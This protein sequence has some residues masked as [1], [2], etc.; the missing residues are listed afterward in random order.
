M[1]NLSIN[2]LLCSKS[3]PRSSDSSWTLILTFSNHKFPG[4]CTR[5]IIRSRYST[6]TLQT[7]YPGMM[8]KS[9]GANP[10]C[11]LFTIIGLNELLSWYWPINIVV[12]H[13]QS[14]KASLIELWF[15]INWKLSDWAKYIER[16][17]CMFLGDI[18][19][20]FPMRTSTAY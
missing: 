12:T 4:T 11:S 10:I 15:G 3:L 19:L 16:D 5:L 1:L 17:Y 20:K 9:E 14:F 8:V 13:R 2:R 18:F 7:N 6:K